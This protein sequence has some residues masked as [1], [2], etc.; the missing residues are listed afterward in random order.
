MTN[1]LYFLHKLL[2]LLISII[3]PI[4]VMF[5]FFYSPPFY[6]IPCSNQ[7]LTELYKTF[8]RPLVL[9]DVICWYCCMH[10]SYNSHF[11]LIISSETPA[12]IDIRSSHDLL[13]S[14]DTAAL[15]FTTSSKSNF[16][17]SRAIH[18][19]FKKLCVFVLVSYPTCSRYL[20]TLLAGIQS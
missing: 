14:R 1:K 18:T 12:F 2:T 10:I 4:S 8:H 7:S 6:T 20:L 13:T 3:I 5:R 19:A 11:K 9:L 17:T 15:T 16:P